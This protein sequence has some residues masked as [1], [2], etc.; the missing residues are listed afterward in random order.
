[1]LTIGPVAFSLLLD[2]DVV[3]VATALDSPDVARFLCYDDVTDVRWAVCR[4]WRKDIAGEAITFVIRRA[5][6]FVGWTGLLMIGEVPG[7]LQ[8]STFLHPDTWGS[9]INVRAKHVLWAMTE[10]LGRERMLFSIDSSNMRSQG[11]L[12]KLFPEASVVWLAAP[13]EPGVDVVLA[14]TKGPHAPGALD[15]AEHVWRTPDHLAEPLKV[16]NRS[17]A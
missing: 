1:M 10:L 8:T 2:E 11:A 17:V 4:R 14:T 9:G 5:G 7:E 12:W 16:A 3:E 15:A 6:R 13:G